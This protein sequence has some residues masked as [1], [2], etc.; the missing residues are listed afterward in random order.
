LIARMASS[1]PI[2]KRGSLIVFPVRMAQADIERVR[3]LAD[4]HGLSSSEWVRS[5]VADKM[6]V[7]EAPPSY[8]VVKSTSTINI[9]A[10]LLTTAK[11]LDAVMRRAGAAVD[12]LEAAAECLDGMH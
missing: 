4:K 3:V 6:V 12:R 7:G 8:S 9:V 5:A 1:Q 10:Q 11:R 2:E